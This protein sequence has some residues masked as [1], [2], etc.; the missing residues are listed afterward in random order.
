MCWG[1]PEK[2]QPSVSFSGLRSQQAVRCSHPPVPY[3]YSV[4]LKS[5]YGVGVFIA[6]ASIL[7]IWSSSSS[8]GDTRLSRRQGSGS[9]VSS[10]P[11]LCSQS[12]MSS[13]SFPWSDLCC[14]TPYCTAFWH[15][16]PLWGRH[17]RWWV[18][19]LFAVLFFCLE[20]GDGF[21]FLETNEL[22]VA[23]MP[24]IPFWKLPAKRH[25]CIRY[26]VFFLPKPACCQRG[27]CYLCM[28]SWHFNK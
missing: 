27:F 17:A 6:S 3:K 23:F 11:A 16:G 18:D 22:M 10:P 5:L 25:A 28:M 7:H 1:L 19:R 20:Y 14:S 12:T 13:G 4:W 8:G 9:W 21:S 26:L 24:R 2:W 15:S